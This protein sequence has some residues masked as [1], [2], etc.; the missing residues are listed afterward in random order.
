MKRILFFIWVIT[1]AHQSNAQVHIVAEL[2]GYG[3]SRSLELPHKRIFKTT[4]TFDLGHL[5]LSFGDRLSLMGGAELLI[6]TNDY[7]YHT[8]Y[9]ETLSK[10]VPDLIYSIPEYGNAF[11][12]LAV[13]LHARYAFRKSFLGPF[14]LGFKYAWRPNTFDHLDAHQAIGRGI[15]PITGSNTVQDF[16]RYQLLGA[17]VPSA[18]PSITLRKYLNTN[19]IQFF[20][21]PYLSISTFTVMTSEI[22]LSE[23]WSGDEYTYARPVVPEVGI[24]IAARWRREVHWFDAFKNLFVPIEE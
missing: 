7:Q 15:D 22:R 1:W 10:A 13:Q 4:H 14:E 5:G 18:V 11:G 8:R 2:P 19:R 24:K 21:E 23:G 9:F 6:V 16:N 3:V 17:F 12:Y 20:V